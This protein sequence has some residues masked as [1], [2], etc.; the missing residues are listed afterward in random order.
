MNSSSAR[1]PVCPSSSALRLG[2]R[3]HHQSTAWMRNLSL[4]P[5]PFPS[6]TTNIEPIVKSHKFYLLHFTICLPLGCLQPIHSPNGP[7][8]TSP[9]NTSDV[10]I[11]GLRVCRAIYDLVPAELSGLSPL[12]LPY[13]VHSHDLFQCFLRCHVLRQTS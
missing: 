13:L 5:D 11:S 6:F 12:T 10:V 9:V 7:R 1:G 3:N 4:I 8:V 2:Q